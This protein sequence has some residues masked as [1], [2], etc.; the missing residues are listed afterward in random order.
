MYPEQ[1]SMESEFLKKVFSEFYKNNF[2]DSVP[3][4]SN[5]EFG[6]GVFRRK[7]ANRNMAFSS[8][9]E[10][11]SFLRENKPLFFSYSNALYKHPER[12]PMSAK[13]LF[14]A[15]IIYEFDADELG[16]NVPE[17]EGIQWFNNFHLSEAKKQVFRLLDFIESDFGFS[18]EGLSI[19]FSGKA[20][21][22][23]HL[24][25][26]SVQGLNKKARIEL[27]DYLTAQN[28]DLTN[29]GFDF[30]VTPFSCPVNKGL[31][32]KRLLGGVKDFLEKDVKE[33]SKL[34]HVPA[35][36]VSVLL[37]EK[38]KLFDS[39]EK[40]TL[41]QLEGKKSKEFWTNVL[42]F[43]VARER[44]PIDRQT[45]IDL[46]K[47]IRVPETLHGE[48]GFI[49]KTLSVDELKNFDPFVDAVVFDSKFAKTIGLDFVRVLTKSVPP[50]SLMGKD[51]GPFEN[52]EIDLPLFAAVYLIGKGAAV[53]VKK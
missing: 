27:V 16:L 32:G 14:K 41:L 33:I 35:K 18:F 42:G 2:V 8:A 52:E 26:E 3:S 45:S 25:S 31:W 46:H 17:I 5:R 39:M 34:T 29:L 10:M 37:D 53:L 38:K 9:E 47:I 21:F 11:N 13:E 19:N 20:G 7:I 24:R 23:V 22:H 43:V 12:T 40:G 49:S 51:F 1:Q 4:V 48:T 28:I 15:D 30:E 6:F 36:K 50:F 44:V